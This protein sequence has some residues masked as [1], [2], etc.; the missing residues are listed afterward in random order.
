MMRTVLL[1]T[2]LIPGLIWANEADQI[3]NDYTAYADQYIIDISKGKTGENE[4]SRLEIMANVKG[5]SFAHAD[6]LKSILQKSASYLDKHKNNDQMRNSPEYRRVL[7]LAKKLKR[8]KKMEVRLID[9]GCLTHDDEDLRAMSDK[10]LRGALSVSPC[11][12]PPTTAEDIT[13]F[14]AQIDEISDCLEEDGNCRKK[15]GIYAAPIDKKVAMLKK[16]TSYSKDQERL[17]KGLIDFVFKGKCSSSMK[18]EE[19]DQLKRTVGKNFPP[20]SMDEHAEFIKNTGKQY[21]NFLKD[22]NINKVK[23]KLNEAM[24]ND[25]FRHKTMPGGW[26]DNEDEGNVVLTGL[27]KPNSGVSLEDFEG[28]FNQAIESVHGKN[29][30]EEAQKALM[31]SPARFATPGALEECTPK[32]HTFM[33]ESQVLKG[34]AGVVRRPRANKYTMVLRN[35]PDDIDKRKMECLYK[36]TMENFKDSSKNHTKLY[37]KVIDKADK[38]VKSME[39]LKKLQA[40]SSGRSRHAHNVAI[41]NIKKDL[42]Y[43]LDKAIMHAI[44]EDPI[45]YNRYLMEN[46]GPDDLDNICKTLQTS[47]KK[48]HD[49]N[50]GKNIKFA[51]ASGAAATF[52]IAGLVASGPIGWA[53]LGASLATAG[54]E[55]TMYRNKAAYYDKQNIASQSNDVFL[56]QIRNADNEVALDEL[57]L[58]SHNYLKQDDKVNKAKFWQ[59][60]ATVTGGM[61][62]LGG[63][64]KAATKVA[65]GAK[66]VTSAEKASTPLGKAVSNFGTSNVGKQVANMYSSMS[67]AFNNTK[68]ADKGGKMTN[69]LFGMLKNPEY[70]KVFQRAA[71][72][73]KASM[74]KIIH[75]LHEAFEVA[76]KRALAPSEISSAGY[77]MVDYSQ[78][79]MYIGA[80]KRLYDMTRTDPNRTQASAY[81][82][83][84]PQESGNL[85]QEDFYMDASTP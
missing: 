83:E 54:I 26:F 60:F 85:E 20:K 63:T 61:G 32:L 56:Q 70:S 76:E 23:A 24:P 80:V 1:L 13:D 15:K 55:A 14:L 5:R 35:I 57:R 67:K 48:Y 22:E 44:T 49:Y 42:E 82:E 34:K 52:A 29:P 46:G 84:G 10:M 17:G 33:Q 43:D 41:R 30:I 78:T 28:K 53:L 79:A 59:Y 64:I 81:S 51:I 74:D 71:N 37:D 75:R 77:W 36:N 69:Y 68:L 25:H 31:S 4:T 62:A 58:A 2:L 18:P 11:I 9:D 27:V 65:H 66:A 16:I 21:N 73:D 12:A 45:A 7:A 40:K 8:F 6:Q 39:N 72:G 50:E 38:K 19:C 3:F 47:M